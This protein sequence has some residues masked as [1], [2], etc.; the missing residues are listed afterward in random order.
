MPNLLCTRAMLSNR[1]GKHKAVALE[2]VERPGGGCVFNPF[3]E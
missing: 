1:L 2:I 3:G